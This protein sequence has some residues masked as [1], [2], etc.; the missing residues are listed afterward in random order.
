ML[1]LLVKHIKE[2]YYL[3]KYLDFTIKKIKSFKANIR[4]N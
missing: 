3:E 4:N 1:A 2:F